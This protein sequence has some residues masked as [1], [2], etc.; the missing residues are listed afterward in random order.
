ME[1]GRSIREKVELLRKK[2]AL[3]S[4]NLEQYHV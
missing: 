3:L 1:I 4:R 2:A